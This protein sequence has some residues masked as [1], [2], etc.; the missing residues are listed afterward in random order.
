MCIQ[1]QH[2]YPGAQPGVVLMQTDAGVVPQ[3][4]PAMSQQPVY[5]AQQVTIDL[6][7]VLIYD[8]IQGQTK[9]FEIMEV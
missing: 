6:T 4:Y 8:T 5:I 2:I 9:K 1:P 7:Y 3:G